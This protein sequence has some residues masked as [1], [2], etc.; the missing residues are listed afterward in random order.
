MAKAFTFNFKI[1]I[2]ND[3]DEDD[4]GDDDDNDG[5]DDDGNDK[6][7]LS[8]TS[9]QRKHLLV[10]QSASNP[11]DIKSFFQP[12]ALSFYEVQNMKNSPVGS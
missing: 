1:K 6:Q 3:D 12:S 11:A 5:D 10:Y 8:S 2:D 4:D 9:G 7:N